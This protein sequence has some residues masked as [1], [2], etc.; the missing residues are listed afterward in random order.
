MLRNILLIFFCFILQIP[1]TAQSITKVAIKKVVIDPGHGGK[2][3][4]AVSINKKHQEKDITLSVS[5]MLGKLIKEAYP[6]VEIIYTRSTDVFVPLDIRSQI[7]NKEKADLFISIHVNSA[8]AKT[9]SGTETFVM[10][11]DK[12]SS[13]LE[14]SKLENSVIVLEG[15]DYSSKYEGFDPNIPDSYIIF[16]LLQ[17]AHLEQSLSFASLVQEQLASGSIKINRGVKQAGLVVLWRTTMPSVLVELGFLSNSSDL[18]VLIQQ[19]NQERMAKSI[20]EAFSKYKRFYD[21][22]STVSTPVKQTPPEKPIQQKTP[23]KTIKQTTPEKAIIQ[24]PDTTDKRIISQTSLS[25]YSI[26]ILAVTKILNKNAPDLKGIKEFDYKQIGG[27]YKYHTGSFTDYSK[28][29]EAL[30]EVR[31]TFPQ[32]FIIRIKNNTIVPLK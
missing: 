13:N 25:I 20:L 21:G 27:Y 24:A 31:R 3:P 15:D 28:A 6:D 8:K 2:D 17:N 11:L 23:E 1:A 14:V 9:A 22:E 30:K 7:A 19:G 5:L 26:Q 10:G 12:S 32:A 29:T 4:G 18:E 16:S